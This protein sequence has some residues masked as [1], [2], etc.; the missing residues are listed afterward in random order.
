MKL[1]AEFDRRI[2]KRR[3]RI[4]RHGEFLGDIIEAQHD[5][6]LLIGNFQI[7]ELVL[8]DDGNFLR[9]ARLQLRRNA[10]AGEIRLER[11]EEMML[12]RQAEFID[13]DER[14]AHHVAHGGVDQA[15]V[16]YRVVHRGSWG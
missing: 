6:K 5:R 4:K 14:L 3:Q 10:H 9:V 11:N 12:P 8:H 15:G 13:M 16:I 1:Q 7:P 2:R